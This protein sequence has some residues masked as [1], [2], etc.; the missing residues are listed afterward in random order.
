[1]LQQHGA[2]TDQSQYTIITHTKPESCAR[3]RMQDR[4]LVKKARLPCF[5]VL[6]MQCDCTY[7]WPDRMMGFLDGVTTSDAG[8]GSKWHLTITEL[9]PTMWH[10][11]YPL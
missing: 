10:Q 11:C 1:M 7:A 4:L 9:C 8:E 2:L 5:G 3:A 6:W